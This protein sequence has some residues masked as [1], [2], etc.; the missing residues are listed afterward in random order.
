MSAA[1]QM[2]R[3]AGAYGSSP[4]RLESECQS[5]GACGIHAQSTPSEYAA[6]EDL[7]KQHRAWPH[8]EH[9]HHARQRIAGRPRCFH[10]DDICKIVP[11]PYYGPAFHDQPILALDKVRYVG[12]AVAVVLADDPH[13][14]EQAVQLIVADYEE[15]PAVLTRSK[16]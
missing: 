5:N 16:R 1:D 10:G 12:E 8:S 6:W 15:L 9:R 4:P 14:A 3:P 7:S 2:T 13:T 11:H